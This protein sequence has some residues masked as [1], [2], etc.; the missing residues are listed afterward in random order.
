MPVRTFR[1]LVMVV[2]AALLAAPAA[3]AA[4]VD[5]ERQRL[6]DLFFYVRSLDRGWDPLLAEIGATLD[7][8][9]SVPDAERRPVLVLRDDAT[10]QRA[11]Q[12][13]AQGESTEERCLAL[14]EALARGAV[15]PARRSASSQR[16]ADIFIRRGERLEKAG[17]EAGAFAAYLGAVDHAPDYDAGYRKVGALGVAQAQRQSDAQDFDRALATLGDALRRIEPKLGAADASVS[18]ATGLRDTI[19]RTTG[20][21]SVRFLAA[22][23]VARVRGARTDLAGGTLLLSAVD[24]KAS[25]PAFPAADARRV[26]AGTYRALLSGPGG[27]ASLNADVEV[28]PEGGSLTAPA[29]LPEGMAYVPGRP[30]APAFLCDRTEVSNAAYDEF[31]RA[32]GRAARGRD[33]RIAAAGVLLADARDYA[34]WSGKS[35]PTLDQW[36]HAAFGAPR[37]RSPRY[38][39]GESEGRPGVHFFSGDRSE[40]GPVDGCAAGASPFGILNLAGNVYEWLDDGWFI[41]GGFSAGVF[42]NTVSYGNPVN[43]EPT[44][45]ADFLRDEIPTPEVYETLSPELKNKH[46]VYRVKRENF[47]R[48]VAEIGFRCVVPLE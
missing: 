18:R 47:D 1:P 11:E 29:A 7:R 44:W 42:Q 24:G 4:G 27:A 21:L 30:G 39:W 14:F 10:W 46:N 8:L 13:Y 41:G 45:E 15:D 34:A 32:R 35:L 12:L 26:R 20:V 25:P 40:P 3:R 2:A 38:P 48:F 17:D 33:P 5:D 31:L 23:R 16:L 28:R 19:L 43:G 37:A 36:T 6:D 9:E 22:D